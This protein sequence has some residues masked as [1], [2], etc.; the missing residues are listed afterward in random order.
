MIDQDLS[1]LASPEDLADWRMVLAYEAA[2]DAGL[3]DA[4]PGAHAD[5]ATRCD[6][7]D[8]ALR[9]VLGQLVAWGIVTEGPPG[10]TSSA[11]RC[12]PTPG[13]GVAPARRDDPPVG[14]SW[15]HGCMTAR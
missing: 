13:C 2:A 7:H 12:R 3:I 8:G 11:R 1:F 14:R 6:L 10:T 9:A 15:D 5:L 4:L